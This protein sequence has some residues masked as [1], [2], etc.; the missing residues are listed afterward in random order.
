MNFISKFN[1]QINTNMY[2][3]KLNYNIWNWFTTSSFYQDTDIQTD[4]NLTSNKSVKDSYVGLVNSANKT[5]TEEQQHICIKVYMNTFSLNSEILFLPL[6][7]D[8]FEIEP[9]VYTL[10]GKPKDE[11][12]HSDDIKP[13]K[14]IFLHNSKK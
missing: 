11:E 1:I 12:A 3:Q 9:A 5:S 7:Y 4:E 14:N 10:Q 6:E 8:D 13:K 2:Y